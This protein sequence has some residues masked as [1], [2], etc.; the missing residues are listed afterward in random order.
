MGTKLNQHSKSLAPG[1]VAMYD[2][3]PQEAPSADPVMQPHMFQFREQPRDEEIHLPESY[4]RGI[5]VKGRMDSYW[6]NRV[7][8]DFKPKA[9]M[10]KRAELEMMI[11]KIKTK[12]RQPVQRVNINDIADIGNLSM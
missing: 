12:P 4:E 7:V 6:R 11:D 3:Q 2:I 10:K 8:R 9:S 1:R 5:I